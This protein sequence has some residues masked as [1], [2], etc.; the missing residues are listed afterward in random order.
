MALAA[1]ALVPYALLCYY[2]VEIVVVAGWAELVRLELKRREQEVFTLPSLFWFS[3]VLAPS[4]IAGAVTTELWHEV[5]PTAS[6]AER[7]ITTYL[8]MSCV[9]W[10]FGFDLDENGNDWLRLAE[11]LVKVA[12]GASI[13]FKR[14]APAAAPPTYRVAFAA[15]AYLAFFEMWLYVAGRPC[16]VPVLYALGSTKFMT[17]PLADRLWDSEDSA[18]EPVEA[19]SSEDESDLEQHSDDD[20][21]EPVDMEEFAQWRV[22]TSL[23]QH[24]ILNARF[25]GVKTPVSPEGWRKRMLTMPMEVRD[26]LRKPLGFSE[27]QVSECLEYVLSLPPK[28]FRRILEFAEKQADEMAGQMPEFTDP[29]RDDG[30]S[31]QRASEEKLRTRRVVKVAD[32]F[33]SAEAE[34][35]ARAKVKAMAA[36]AEAKAA[37]TDRLRREAADSFAL[38]DP[39][40]RTEP[41]KRELAARKWKAREKEKEE[42]L[43]AK[44]K[45]VEERR[46]KQAEREAA[47]REEAARAEA[48][49]SPSPDDDEAET[50]SEASVEAEVK[51]KAADQAAAELLAA[52]EA[53]AAAAAAKKKKK[54]R[55]G[56]RGG[57]A[58]IPAVEAPT[59]EQHDELSA[60]VSELLRRLG[61]DERVGPIFAREQIDENALPFLTVE[62]LVEAGVADEDARKVVSAAAVPDA[63]PAAEPEDAAAEE[64]A[65]AAEDPP[66]AD[67]KQIP[68]R[69]CCPISLELMVRPVIAADGHTYDRSSIEDWLARGNTTSP[70]TGAPLEHLHLADN[71]LVRS[72]VSEY[73]D[74]LASR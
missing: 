3:L 49:R 18:D 67:S 56:K 14:I 61:L 34:A 60:D 51:A 58:P 21:G 68:E 22:A 17:S 10:I 31:F 4:T 48:E 66:V 9:D 1:G 7:F 5:D 45:Q 39:A 57:A 23:L 42:K 54:K 25:H 32:R 40:A 50:E 11:R 65:P 26:S 72:M 15:L 24:A 71:H 27:D 43:R 46:R 6:P 63:E 53:T 44:R 59:V 41:S 55:R 36:E 30:G 74:S 2:K 69:L 52:E 38:P 47:A 33:R 19:A 29:S 35:G 12:Y 28:D 37:E 62:D 64:P 70:T 73:Q 16:R 8:G 13:V 20:E